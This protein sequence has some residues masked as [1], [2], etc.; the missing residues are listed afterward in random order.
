MKRKQFTVELRESMAIPVMATEFPAGWLDDYAPW[1][2]NKASDML[3]GDVMTKG[4]IT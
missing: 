4:G 3:L 1:I 2:M